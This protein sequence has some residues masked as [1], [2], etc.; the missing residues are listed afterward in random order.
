MKKRPIEAVIN[1]A[2]IQKSTTIR[3][4]GYE[5]ESIPEALFE[6]DFLLNQ[7]RFF[8]VSEDRAEEELL[9]AAGEQPQ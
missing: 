7:P 6:L 4:D 8:F 3:L 2:K 5:L 1:E 9:G